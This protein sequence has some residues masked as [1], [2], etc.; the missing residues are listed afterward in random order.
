LL[1]FW[2]SFADIIAVT[3]PPRKRSLIGQVQSKAEKINSVDEKLPRTGVEDLAMLRER[4]A[5]SRASETV[6]QHEA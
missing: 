6:Q 4:V 2:Y 3:M 1:L 5:T